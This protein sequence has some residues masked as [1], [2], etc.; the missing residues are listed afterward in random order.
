MRGLLLKDWY[1]IIRYCR[2][3]FLLDA[4]FIAVSL[5]APENVYFMTFPCLF[6]AMIPV[7][8][9]SYDEREKWL[10][11][12]A[13]LPASRALQ[14]SAKYLL[15]LAAVCAVLAVNALAQSAATLLL[16]DRSGTRFLPMLLTASAL[17]L[18]LPGIMLP[19]MYRFGAEKARI[20]YAVL[21]GVLCALSFVLMQRDEAPGATGTAPLAPALLLPGALALY[22]VSWLVSIALYRRRE[23]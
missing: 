14:V 22:G 2:S 4:V 16:P 13:V 6:S 12:S 19:L 8:L 20:V 5:V 15:G 10:N 18:L 3:F 1:L 17:A 23:L 21:V 11:Y 7:T 9:F